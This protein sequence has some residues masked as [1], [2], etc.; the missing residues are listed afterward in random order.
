MESLFGLLAGFLF[1]AVILVIGF[2][3]AQGII[4]TKLN[5]LM[6]GKGTPMAWIPLAN[7]YLLGKLTVNKI[8]GWVLI[9]FFILS[10]SVSI[11]INGNETTYG[12]LPE[13]IRSI[14]STIYSLVAFVLFIY[15]I[16]KYVKLKKSGGVSNTNSLNNL[17]QTPGQVGVVLSDNQPLNNNVEN[18]TPLGKTDLSIEQSN[19]NQ[20]VENNQTINNNVV[21]NVAP[22]GNI[23]PSTEQ[24]NFNQPAESNQVSNGNFENIT[25]PG[26]TEP[27]TEQ[28]NLNQAVESNQ[29]S[30]DNVEN[31]TQPGNTES[32][33]EPVNLDQPVENIQPLNNT[34]ENIVPNEHADVTFT[35]ENIVNNSN[36][37]EEPM[38]P[39]IEMDNEVQQESVPLNQ[40]AEENN[41]SN[42]T[43]NIENASTLD[44]ADNNDD[45]VKITLDTNDDNKENEPKPFSFD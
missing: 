34:V 6:Y 31:I 41:M 13:N 30:N 21:A 33:T 19:L 40:M 3:V 9:A 10:C 32:L 42:S 27:S 7:V 29:V 11:S 25:Q 14:V 35:P 4:L 39:D 37:N 23:E 5:K 26:N 2:Y 1:V 22:M 17:E 28:F 44:I 8:V 43:S 20:T 16:V 18:V 36:V 15:A 45:V 12:I 38:V 24:F